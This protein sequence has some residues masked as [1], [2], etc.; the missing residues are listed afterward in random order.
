[1]ATRVFA[2]SLFNTVWKN[3]EGHVLHV[4]T[5][6]SV[7]KMWVTT[8]DGNATAIGIG[9]E[10]NFYYQSGNTPIGSGTAFF[11]GKTPGG[12][13]NLA[14]GFKVN[15]T[16]D[17]LSTATPPTALSVEIDVAR[18]AG[19]IT[20]PTGTGFNY[21]R[22]FPM[23]D[24]ISRPAIDDYQGTLNYINS[25]SAN[26]DQ[27]GN[28][29]TGF[30][31]WNFTYPT[32]ADT[33]LNTVN[34]PIP[35]FEAATNG[36]VNFGGTV[37]SLNAVGMS[38]ATW[39]DPGVSNSWAALWTVLLPAPAPLGVI[40]TGYTTNSNSFTYTV[41]AGTLP[42]TVDVS[43]TGGSST[44]VYQVKL[45]NGVITITPSTATNLTANTTVKVFGVP[46]TVGGV[47]SI[48]AYV[49]FYYSGTVS[50]Q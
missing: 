17:P 41:P 1:V 45:Q 37:G 27:A 13:P 22:N 29:V 33:S 11:N 14:R 44:L 42:V 21:T 16:I 7:E 3:P 15:V 6:P 48:K 12:L 26:T 8:E 28:A 49:V 24:A 38:N 50:T 20:S 23:A 32:L 4:N 47:S 46:Q 40:G 39:N 36:S 18:Y 2:G 43:T 34:G 35:D 10:T 25:S 19:T 5:N 30:Y 31:W 9:S